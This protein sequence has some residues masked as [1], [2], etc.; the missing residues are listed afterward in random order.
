MK[1]IF[2]YT[3]LQRI[4][5]IIIYCVIMFCVA[6]IEL[7]FLGTV[8]SPDEGFYLLWFVLTLITLTVIPLFLFI[9]CSSGYAHKLLFTNESYLMLTLPVRIEQVL[10]GRML[11]GLVELIICSL[12]SVLL[13]LIVLIYWGHQ[14]Q[15]NMSMTLTVLKD[16]FFFIFVKNFKFLCAAFSMLC[17]VFCLI[18]NAALFVQTLVRSFNIKRMKGVWVVGFVLICAGI[19]FLIGNIEAQALESFGRY[20][21][22]TGYNMHYD[23]GTRLVYE[24]TAI[25]LPAVSMFIS[26][27]LGSG[28]FLISAQLFKKRVEV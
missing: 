19:L 12:V 18:G 15:P 17:T 3:F 25:N 4:P 7:A 6:V 24:P 16:G 28:L 20:C 13:L 27:M 23:E 22:I 5:S 14:Y 9:K 10:L 11:V 1:R 21:L 2:K 8:K 26:L